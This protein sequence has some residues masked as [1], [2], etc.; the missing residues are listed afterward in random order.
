M[1]EKKCGEKISNNVDKFQI[2]FI[3]VTTILK[4]QRINNFEKT[5][6]NTMMLEKRA[7]GLIQHVHEEEESE[8]AYWNNK[9]FENASQ[10]NE[11]R[12]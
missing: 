12:I 1:L 11:N 7:W 5:K 2:V 8:L 10:F 6:F 3:L 4:K 9:I